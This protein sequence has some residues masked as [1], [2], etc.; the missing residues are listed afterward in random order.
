MYV[1]E[2]ITPCIQSMQLQAGDTGMAFGPVQIDHTY[3][4]T[5][6]FIIVWMLVGASYDILDVLGSRI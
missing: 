5:C 3:W 1:L 2:G 4:K 6:P